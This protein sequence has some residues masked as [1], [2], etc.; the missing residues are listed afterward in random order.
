MTKKSRVRPKVGDIIEID[1]PDGF[2]YAQYTH[3]HREPPV[4]G[5]LI[6]VW[7]GTFE[8][9]PNS[10]DALMERDEKF[11]TFCPLAA[12]IKEG[13]C[14]IVENHEIPDRWVEF[15]LFK[16]GNENFETGRISNWWLWDGESSTNVGELDPKHYDLPMKQIVTIPL[17]VD[18]ILS[19]WTARDEVDIDE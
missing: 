13:F 6:R 7:P 1:T 11:T 16:A 12:S 2:A 3:N 5:E 17:I 14:R 15:P 19:G 8:R 9:R 18:R 4:Y 10:F